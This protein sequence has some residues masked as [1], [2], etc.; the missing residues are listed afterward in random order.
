MSFTLS[1]ITNSYV[2][3]QDG[4]ITIGGEKLGGYKS[5]SL[6]FSA[7]T[8]DN[9]T[10]DDQGW[11]KQRRRLPGGAHLAIFGRELQR[12]GRRS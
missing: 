5:G 6:S 10:R 3:G 7:E 11:T 1:D 8:V 12:K 4:E 9:S 2:L